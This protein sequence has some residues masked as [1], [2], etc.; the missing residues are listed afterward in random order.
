[1]TY[2]YDRRSIDLGSASFNLVD[3]E[4]QKAR[5]INSM[6]NKLTKRKVQ[7]D[8]EDVFYALDTTV[9]RKQTELTIPSYFDAAKLN[10]IPKGPFDPRLT[11]AAYYNYLIH[12]PRPLGEIELPFHWSDWVD[13]S[14]IDPIIYKTVTN[15]SCNY[16]DHRQY[17]NET[18]GNTKEENDLHNG[19][20]SPKAFCNITRGNSSDLDIGF[21]FTKHYGRM[22]EKQAILAARSYLYT[23]APN[24]ESILFLTKD[25]SYHVRVSREPSALINGN[26]VSN[27]LASY[28]KKH[29]SI[30]TL[31]VFKALRKA[32]PSEKEF[33]VADY[34]IHLKHEDFILDVPKTL[35]D[36]D[37]IQNERQLTRHEQN[38]QNALLNSLALQ[39]DPPKYFQEAKVYDS[40]VA[41]HHDWRFFNGFNY[42]T[43]EASLTLHRLTRTWLSFTR[44]LGLNSWVAHGSLLAWHFNGM[45]FPWDD[46]VD[47]QMPI[48]DLLKLS[49]YFNQT[50]IVEDA[51]DGFGRFFLDC[52]TYITSR[53]HGNG[54]NNIDARFIDVDTG[55]YIDITALAV[56]SDKADERFN[57]LIPA[58]FKDLAVPT[59][60]I[61]KSV[62][63][64]NC[65]NYHF[66][67]HAE[68][69]PLVRTFF[70]GELAYVPKNYP[71]ILSQ[72]YKDGYT[73]RYHNGW[74]YLSQLRIW[75]HQ[76]VL[77][78]FLR[79]PTEWDEF[80]ETRSYLRTKLLPEVNGGISNNEFLTLQN[81]SENDI[82]RLLHHDE[83][84]LR[85]Q[86]SKD[87]TMFHE[88]EGMR[89]QV[90]K[91]TEAMVELAPDLPPLR[92]EPFLAL[93][94]ETFH[95][96]EGNVE[97][98]EKLAEHVS[99][100]SKTKQVSVQKLENKI[101][102]AGENDI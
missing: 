29:K 18:Y 16:F 48:Q 25:G 80:F 19:A 13:M 46:D 83:I 64:Y 85:Y 45:N 68:V 3:Y 22:T 71:A 27:S 44:K 62:R 40:R 96:F 84:F 82:F 38:F 102:Q 95:D 5:R 6:A 23:L 57:Q 35:L 24:P 20:L 99:R 55:M 66:V 89:L 14:V 100:N 78:A 81:L 56:S 63:L 4:I 79:H 74:V 60:D 12:N 39:D 94:R 58:V 7:E 92:Y 47:V 70:D 49:E 51:E 9:R 11:L 65:R 17:E 15:F 42:Q 77:M 59:I 53:E 21:V 93:M 37:R 32:R 8:V 76:R 34:E 69:S 1:M 10:K 101:E 36:I 41:D 98:Y 52:A 61:N 88:T 97:R 31:D 43:E 75:V 28:K 2:S 30:N 50:M 72:E 54:N 67:S 87:I 90:G 91:S 33:V 86:K 73:R 26:A